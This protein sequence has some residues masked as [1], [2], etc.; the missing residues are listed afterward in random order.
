MLDNVIHD[1]GGR[2]IDAACL[3][4]LRLFLD[5]GPGTG[6]QADDL[7]QELLVHLAQ[8]VGWQHRELVGAL[9]V[10]EAGQD[11]L[12]HPVVN[13]QRRGQRVGL[14]VKEAGVVLFV[15]LAV[16]V[17]QAGVDVGAA[18]EGQEAAV[19]FDAPV[20]GLSQSRKKWYSSEL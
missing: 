16:E 1:V 12:E 11:G 4:D 14:K 5:F 3:F 2:V 13:G 18:G 15:G 10:V 19:F 17:A 8:D 7:A 6:R 9:G 20:L